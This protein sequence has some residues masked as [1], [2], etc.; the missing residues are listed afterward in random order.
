MCRAKCVSHGAPPPP[1]PGRP[2]Y[3]RPLSPRRQ[4]PAVMAFTTDSNR[5]QPLWQHPPTA[6]LAASGAASEA[7]SLLMCPCPLGQSRSASDHTPRALLT[8]SVVGWRKPQ[9]TRPTDSPCSPCV[10]LPCPAAGPRST[11]HTHPPPQPARQQKVRSLMETEGALLCRNIHT[12][13]AV[14]PSHQR[15]AGVWG[16]SAVG[17]AVRPDNEGGPQLSR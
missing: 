12:G 16:S 6:C 11:G 5:T 1:P 15:V 13:T 8:G 7:P 2:A 4:V 3:A 14:S 17:A 10:G 9:V